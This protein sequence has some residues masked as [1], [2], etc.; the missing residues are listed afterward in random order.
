MLAR[1]EYFFVVIIFHTSHFFDNF[2]SCRF[3]TSLFSIY[4]FIIKEYAIPK[5]NMLCNLC[6]LKTRLRLLCNK[7]QQHSSLNLVSQRLKLCNI[8]I[9]G[10]AYCFCLV[11]K[12]TLLRFGIAHPRASNFFSTDDDISISEITSS[13][14]HLPTV[15]EC[16]DLHA[17]SE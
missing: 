3:P 12:Q 7:Y 17:M 1:R 11:E 16:D 10:M 2:Y 15:F 14:E 8:F 13:V 9:F 4:K 6:C 5:I